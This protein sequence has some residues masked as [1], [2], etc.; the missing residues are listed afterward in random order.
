M[1]NIV[2]Q[3]LS[4]SVSAEENGK[5]I[6]LSPAQILEVTLDS[7]PTTGYSWALSDGSTVPL[8]FAG[9]P[10]YIAPN[11][12]RLGA[13][14]IEVLRFD[15]AD[16]G[17][18]ELQLDYVRSFEKDAQPAE[19]FH[20]NVIVVATT[21]ENGS[22]VTLPVGEALAVDLPG[23]PSTGYQW[24]VVDNDGQI[25][26]QTSDPVTISPF[27]MPGA[28]GIQRFTFEG[29]AQGTMTLNMRYVRPWEPEAEPASIF[30]LG[31]T[32]K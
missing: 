25:L 7:N 5:T 1:E 31:V 21:A 17:S 22:S 11:D 18:G 13:G 12:D 16:F 8:S 27:A 6:Y 23:N 30:T 2:A 14:G 4:V 26:A 3:Q 29:V 24:Q 20:L 15:V 10:E 19:T 9:E 32:V 28:G